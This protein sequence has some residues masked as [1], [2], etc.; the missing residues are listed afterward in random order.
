MIRGLVPLVVRIPLPSI[1]VCSVCLV[2]WLLRILPSIGMIR[3]HLSLTP[4]EDFFQLST[5]CLRLIK[6]LP[7][8]R[9]PGRWFLKD[10]RLPG[11]LAEGAAR[12][13][14]AWY[15]SRLPSL[16]FVAGFLG[17]ASPRSAARWHY[18][19]LTIPMISLAKSG[20]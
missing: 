9:R 10:T 6:I 1:V 20:R 18:S 11:A 17:E 3:V 5:S 2:R 4:R 8:Q 14:F 7:S 12:I 19:D 15:A 16:T 13:V